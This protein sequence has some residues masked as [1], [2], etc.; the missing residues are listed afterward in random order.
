MYSRTLLHSY[1]KKKL[2]YGGNFLE[3]LIV[4]MLKEHVTDV[5]LTKAIVLT[6]VWSA[7][8]NEKVTKR[9]EWMV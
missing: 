9:T 6:L 3:A 2:N 5:S 7:T 8:Q 4:D 1:N